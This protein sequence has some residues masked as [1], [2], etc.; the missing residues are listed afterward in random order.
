M[1]T[2]IQINLVL[3]HE[4]GSVPIFSDFGVGVEA[5]TFVLAFKDLKTFKSNLHL[6]I[7]IDIKSN[8]SF[9]TASKSYSPI[10]KKDFINYKTVL[11]PLSA[12]DT[13]IIYYNKHW[14]K[15]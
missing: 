9:L 2:K 5:N 8:L 15:L 12:L 6:K 4:I 1:I 7:A 11:R 14:A 3:P 10:W 13:N